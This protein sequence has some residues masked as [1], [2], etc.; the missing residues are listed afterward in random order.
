[1]PTELVS[2]EAMGQ[3][4]HRNASPKSVGAMTWFWF[5]CTQELLIPHQHIGGLERISSVAPRFLFLLM[6]LCSRRKAS[7][8][9]KTEDCVSF[10]VSAFQFS[11]KYSSDNQ[12]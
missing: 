5:A 7:H 2:K 3:L 6:Q 12:I 9:Y 10:S 4:L 1:M 11:V 8:I